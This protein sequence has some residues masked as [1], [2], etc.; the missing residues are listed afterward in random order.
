M[1]AISTPNTVVLLDELTR[2]P[3]DAFNLLLPLLDGQRY[4]AL[5]ESDAEAIVQVAEGVSFWATA[6][7]GMEYTGTSILD[8]ALRDRFQIIDMDF[9]DEQSEIQILAARCKIPA[10]FAT[11]LAAIAK[12]QRNAAKTQ[13]EFSTMVSTRSLI[14]AGNQFAFGVPFGEAIACCVESMFSAEGDASS[15]RA[16]LHAMVVKEVPPADLGATT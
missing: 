5:D 14:A 2:A 7:E 1:T 15:E 6:N 9:T 4:L 16:K 11:Y 8:R 13:E 3:R 12:R 10:K